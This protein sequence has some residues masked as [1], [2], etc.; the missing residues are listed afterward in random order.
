MPKLVSADTGARE[1]LMYVATVSWEDADSYYAARTAPEWGRYGR[2]YL[3]VEKGCMYLRLFVSACA[4]PW[5]YMVPMIALPKVLTHGGWAPPVAFD[6]TGGYQTLYEVPL[7]ELE[8]V[9]EPVEEPALALVPANC[10]RVFVDGSTDAQQGIAAACL[11]SGEPQASRASLAIPGMTCAEASELLVHGVV[12]L[13]V[14]EEG[15]PLGGGIG[16]GAHR[17][18]SATS[19]VGWWR[20]TPPAPLRAVSASSQP[21]GRNTRARRSVPYPTSGKR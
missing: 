5:W 15:V 17:A 11:I 3:N 8:C 12:N 10:T 7:S 1:Y 9:S 20:L 21:S 19:C 2:R 4:E 16:L 14:K 13:K 6:A 18:S